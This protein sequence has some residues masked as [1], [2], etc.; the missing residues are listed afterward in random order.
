MAAP[1]GEAAIPPDP[2]LNI[3]SF[4]VVVGSSSQSSLPVPLKSPSSLKFE[5]AIFFSDD[6]IERL[7]SPF[8][9]ALVR[10][11]SHGRPSMEFIRKSFLT[12]R[13]KADYKIGLL[14]QKHIFIHLHCEED[15]QRLGYAI[16]GTL[17]DSP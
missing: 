11:F 14:D 3:K 10:K 8:K 1:L 16:Y 9:S 12:F 2:S 7:A 5:P 6:E 17:A 15:Y 4:A 13:L